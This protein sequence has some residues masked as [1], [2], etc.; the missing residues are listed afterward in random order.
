M[1]QRLKDRYETYV[2]QSRAVRENASAMDGF[3]GFGADPRKDPCH[4][5]F[6]QDVERWVAEFRQTE[7]DA[8]TVYAAVEFILAAPSQYKK[9][10]AYWFMYAAQGLC[11]DLIPSLTKE[12]CKELAHMYDRD[13][14]K[15]E[16]FAAQD[17][18]Y[19]ALSRGAR[20]K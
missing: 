19:K 5:A 15:K 6:F 10:D 4:V 3:L 13:F 11:K 1:L 7:A 14:P 16:R 18:V 17:G 8:E 2:Q 20:G 12:H 9:E